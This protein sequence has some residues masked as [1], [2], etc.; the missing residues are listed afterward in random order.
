MIHKGHEKHQ[1][2]STTMFLRKFWVSLILTIP[3]LLYADVVKKIFQWSLP[4]FPGSKYL[5]LLLGSIVF[6]YG[7]WVFLKGALRE[8]QGRLPGMMTLIAIA[9][10]AAYFWSVYAVFVNKEALFWELTTLITIMLLGHWLEMR[11]VSGAQGALKELSKLLPDTAE[12]IR[13]G[14]NKIVS[15]SELK[16]NDIVLVK[17]GGKIPADGKIVEGESDV[18]ESM[19]TGESKP[20][21][22]KITDS[23][24]AGTINGDGALK[25]NISKIGEKTFLAG[26]MR[27]VAEAQ[28]SKS[29]LQILSD[30][31]AFYL[32]IIA[33]IGGI[34][35][36][37]A[38][39]LAGAEVSFAVARL[40]AVLV[41]AC[42]H[43]L[44]LAVPLVASISTTKAAQN[45]FLVKQRTS[46]EA[47]RTI[48]TVL[49]DK[50]GT[51]T[52]GEFGVVNVW[53]TN[54]QTQDETLQLAASLDV[55][56]EHPIAKAVVDKAKEKGLSLKEPKKFEALKGRG[57][58]AIIDDKEIMVG[59]PILLE[60]IGVAVPAE[61]S[62][63]IQDAGRKG[64]TVI[65]TL[66]DK[67]LLGAIALADIIREESR[68][69]I[70]ALKEINVKSAMITGDSEDVA[71]WVS[72]E[73]GIDEY[74]ARVLPD[75][76]SEKVKELQK[77]GLKV[78]MVGDGINDAPAL[79]QADLG[80][81]IGAG[82]NVAIESA[83][84]I[85]VRNDP[86]DIVKIIKLSKLTY[87]KMIQNLFWATG[88]NVIALP[89]AAGALAF[90]GILLD[91]AIGAALMSVSTIIVSI[92][93]VLLRGRKL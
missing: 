48:N 70:R 34:V 33:I 4:D 17:P 28:T 43:A 61:I 42:P 49:F 47:A 18:N 75:K 7:G 41:I 51:L 82:T 6:F 69:A 39:L 11:A 35:T 79:T 92:N 31:A 63:Q 45:G 68:E 64:Q 19:V 88:Y 85:L 32:T 16:E 60:S 59:G 71:K 76:K 57:V 74:F 40:V 77:R 3:V 38:W 80:I 15:L 10:S 5:P 66:K 21:P 90:R 24:I 86:R 67:I 14:T 54:G 62:S 27:L 44:G 73:L 53:N 89:L 83:G 78:A 65:F 1:G 9:I 22:K 26:I 23:I 91:P 50:T 55:L 30:K 29:K 13:N 87:V 20:V 52:K 2:H 58:K 25:I 12:V 81:A 84:I 37:I 46:L 93:A 72:Q 56:S 36:L 8:I